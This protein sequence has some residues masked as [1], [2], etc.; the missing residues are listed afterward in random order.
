MARKLVAILSLD[1]VGYSAL[2]AVDEALTL[3]RLR[4][5]RGDIIDP[6]VASHGG[7][8][9]KWIGD[10][11]LAEFRS[12]VEAFN[13]TTAIVAELQQKKLDPPALAYR[14]GLHVGNVVEEDGALLGDGVNVAARLQAAAKPGEILISDEMRRQVERLVKFPL[15]PAGELSL[16]NLPGR[17][18][19]FRVAIE[20]APLRANVSADSRLSFAVLPFQN[21]SRD[22]DQQ[23][24]C[25]GVV[26]EIISR[27]LR[28]RNASE[29]S[30][31]R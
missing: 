2:V 6:L 11:C 3:K 1:A 18:A 8:V 27:L 26:E 28:G 4:R 24:F 14:F 25:D 22:P 16:R 9:F 20:M 19:S 30:R 12:A 17:Y 29:E 7:R 21:M 5:D 15:V 23:D 13:C 10:G 31:W